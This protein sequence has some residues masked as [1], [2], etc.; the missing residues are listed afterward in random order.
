MVVRN[1][2]IDFAGGALVF[3]G[4][5]VE[6]AD[7]ALGEPFRIAAIREAFEESG[8]L[9][10]LRGDEMLAEHSL[11][12]DGD[13]HALLAEH[14]LTPASDALVP[15]AH[16]IT[17]A[18]MPKRFDTHFFLAEAPAQQVGLHDGDEA[19]ESLWITPGHA[20]AEADAGTRV[21]VFATRLNL[22]RLA[23]FAT[24]HQAMAGAG[25]VVTVCPEPFEDAE[26]KWM[27]IPEAA[28]Y[29]GTVFKAVGR[30]MEP[31]TS[32]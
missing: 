31:V 11:P 17:P 5:R 23:G 18:D 16:W 27:R 8:I 14:A 25:P 1:R 4:G 15:F 3:P 12:R 13:F 32:G 28:G 24:V 20:L 22:A 6:E 2:A 9:L 30:P 10:A 7:A 21:L 19:V 26:G 29:G